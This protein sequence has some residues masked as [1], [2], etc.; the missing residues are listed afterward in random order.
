M[1]E[2]WD[3][4]SVMCHAMLHLF[5]GSAHAWPVVALTCGASALHRDLDIHELVA[6]IYML[7][8]ACNTITLVDHI[9]FVPCMLVAVV[10]SVAHLDAYTC[11]SYYIRRATLFAAVIPAVMIRYTW[12]STP[13][14]SIL[15]LLVYTVISRHSRTQLQIDSWDVAVQCLALLCVPLYLLVI[16]AA[17]PCF[18]LASEWYSRAHG[19]LPVKRSL[20]VRAGILE[21]V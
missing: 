14:G 21:E 7:R 1:F 16:P 8:F 5:I 12:N 2:V 9:A 17:W 6:A 18:V 3:V 15:R 11:A 19:V 10:S 13:Y 4:L 20:R